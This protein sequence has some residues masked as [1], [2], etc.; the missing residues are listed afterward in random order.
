RCVPHLLVVGLWLITSDI[1]TRRTV[2]LGINGRVM[3]KLSLHCGRI[4]LVLRCLWIFFHLDFRRR[5]RCGLWS[6]LWRWSFLQSRAVRINI[7]GRI[8]RSWSFDNRFFLS[9]L[10][11][12]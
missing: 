5:L 11:L 10:L 2:Q 9:R 7:I 3:R 1:Q 12:G 8:L 6:V 4:L